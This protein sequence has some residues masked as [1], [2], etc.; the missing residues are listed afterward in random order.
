MDRGK[1]DEAMELQKILSK[2]DCAHQ[3]GYSGTKAAIEMEYGYGGFP[4]RPLWG[5]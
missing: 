4:R 3:I 5:E 2:G 1:Y